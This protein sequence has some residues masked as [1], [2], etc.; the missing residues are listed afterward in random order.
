VS[1][2]TG[3][4]GRV[5]QRGARA[6]IKC[7]GCCGT[8][9]FHQMPSNVR[10]NKLFSLLDRLRYFH[11]RLAGEKS[12]ISLTMKGG[13][14]LLMRARAKHVNDYGTAYDVFANQ[15]YGADIPEIHDV[16]FIVDLGANVGYASLYLASKYPSASVFAFE[17]NRACGQRALKLFDANGLS[18]RVTLL[19]AAA[20]N[21][22]GVAYFSH[23]GTSARIIQ[24]PTHGFQVNTVDLF[25]WVK[26]KG[27]IDILKMDIESG[28]YPILADSRF[29]ALKCRTIVMEWHD[30]DQHPDGG[31]WCRDR[32]TSLGY[33]VTSYVPD[34]QHKAGLLH[35][36][37]D[38]Q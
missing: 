17:P 4:A 24:N 21:V 25:G 11:W 2:T 28:E 30:T 9:C 7:A 37:N 20:S 38:R 6:S 18:R 34:P 31:A 12:D 8:V 14:I 26:D 3:A 35:A 15:V 32:L 23:G 19:D 27:V 1:F 36:V 22:D 5:M 33:R 29:A 10:F 16:R 13:C